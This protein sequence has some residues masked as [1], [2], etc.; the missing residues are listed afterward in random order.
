MLANNLQQ[1]SGGC[2]GAFLLPTVNC[3]LSPH[4]AYQKSCVVKSLKISTGYAF[5]KALV[6]FRTENVCEIG[7]SEAGGSSCSFAH[8]FSLPEYQYCSCGIWEFFDYGVRIVNRFKIVAVQYDIHGEALYDVLE[9]CDRNHNTRIDLPGVHNDHA[10][11]LT[12]GI[13]G[14]QIIQAHKCANFG[15]VSDNAAFIVD[16]QRTHVV[17]DDNNVLNFIFSQN[18]E[19]FQSF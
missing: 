8:R 6:L 10:I 18:A 2:V 11:K 4:A 17:G 9:Y 19:R 12:E 1:S 16:V 15:S 7:G 3:Q 13:A 5:V 14:L